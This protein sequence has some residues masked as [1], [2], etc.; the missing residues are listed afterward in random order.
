[1]STYWF[2]N[3]RG[4]LRPD[5]SDTDIERIREMA[6]E[7]FDG[8]WLAHP[9]KA[10][11][12]PRGCPSMGPNTRYDWSRFWEF[13]GVS[14]VGGELCLA[15]F[16]TNLEREPAED[17][18]GITAG[19]TGT[20]LDH[21]MRFLAWATVGPAGEVVGCIASE[22]DEDHMHPIVRCGD[23]RIRVVTTTKEHLDGWWSTATEDAHIPTLLPCDLIRDFQGSWAKLDCEALRERYLAV[24]GA[25]SP[26]MLGH[27]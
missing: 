7:R 6:D 25:L 8:T 22:H 14:V 3:F 13:D 24:A 19:A 4:T 5:L 15:V 12:H 27:P 17:E 20:R 2:Y 21:L 18:D 10:D 9:D 26:P 16:A 1:M 23:G 11:W